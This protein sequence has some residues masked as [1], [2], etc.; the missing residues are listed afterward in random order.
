MKKF[1]I[2]AIFLVS[3]DFYLKWESS[4]RPKKYKKKFKL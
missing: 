3:G 1:N 4:L 2:L